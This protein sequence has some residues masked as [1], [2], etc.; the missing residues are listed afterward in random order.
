M[1]WVRIIE[2]EKAEKMIPAGQHKLVKIGE[3]LICLVHNS[4]GWWAIDDTCPH[5]Y[6]SLNQGSQNAF[7][8]IICPLHAYRFNL[9][10][11]AEANNKCRDAITYPVKIESGAIYVDINP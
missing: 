11:G 1:K 10:T 4:K 6:A 2:I 7:N 3:R 9:K 5:E 8:E